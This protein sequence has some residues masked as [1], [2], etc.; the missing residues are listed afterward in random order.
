VLDLSASRSI[1]HN[2]QAFFGIQNLLGKVYFVQTNPST[3]GTPRL[4]NV[5]VRIRFA[6][7]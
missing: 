4:A 6:G 5:G 7:R 2:V 3:I 1:T